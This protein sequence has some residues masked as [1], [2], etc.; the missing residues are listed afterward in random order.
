VVLGEG[1]ERDR[2]RGLARA[3][4]V[5]QHVHLAGFRDDPLPILAAADLVVNPS[6]TE[7]LPNVVLE[8]QSLGVPV[9]ATDGR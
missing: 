4:E 2:L 7:G 6:L 9:V 3:L 1:R 5:S 8:A